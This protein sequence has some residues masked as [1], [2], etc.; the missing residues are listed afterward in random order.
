MENKIK[1]EELEQP[2]VKIVKYL[3][4]NIA[5]KPVLTC[6]EIR[7]VVTCYLE[8]YFKEN[9]ETGFGYDFLGDYPYNPLSAKIAMLKAILVLAT[10]VDGAADLSNDTI[11]NGDTENM[12]YAM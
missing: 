6:D 3:G 12:L 2:Q 4:K 5:I 8:V 11:L 10:N 7:T 1:L 9:E